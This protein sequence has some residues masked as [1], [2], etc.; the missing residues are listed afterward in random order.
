M[1]SSKNYNSIVFLTTLSVYLGFVLIGGT[2]PVLAHAAMTQQFDIQNEIE[3]K[4]DLDKKPDDESI[5]FT[6]SLNSYFKE[7]SDFIKDL[8]RLHKI[9]KFD[10]DYDKFQ[11][12][13]LGFIP[14]NVKGDP[15][16]TAQISK[17]I[18]NRWLEPSIID[19]RYSFEGWNFLSDCLK[20]DKFN[21]GFS[22]SSGLKI[23]YDKSELKIEV[24]A[25]KSSSQRAN[26]IAKRFSQEL[27]AYEIDEDEAIVEQ[28]YKFTSF[29]SEN[30]Q[31]FIVTRLPRGSLDALLINKDA[32]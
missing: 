21:T 8:Q 14:C 32:Q 22:T 30:N 19:A 13:E 23:I 27:I 1:S 29:K 18:D 15:I 2:P 6:E 31:V 9:E 3:V 10:S 17:K 4:D 20:D 7:V 26:W 16:R 5:N 12:S 28:L 25:Y 11:I 24:S